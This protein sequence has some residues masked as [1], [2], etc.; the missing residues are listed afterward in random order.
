MVKKTVDESKKEFNSKLLLL[1]QESIIVNVEYEKAVRMSNLTTTAINCFDAL[2]QQLMKKDT[3]KCCYTTH[4][5][6]WIRAIEQVLL[7][8]RA[9]NAERSADHRLPST[10]KKTVPVTPSSSKPIRRRPSVLVSDGDSDSEKCLSECSTAADDGNGD[11]TDKTFKSKSFLDSA[12]CRSDFRDKEALA[13]YSRAELFMN[14][15]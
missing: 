12:D 15:G 14:S 11:E 8:N 5:K 2:E 7:Q 13:Q 6:R 10:P 3:D 1:H 9:L 4:R